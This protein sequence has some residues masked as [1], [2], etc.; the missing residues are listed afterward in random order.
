V[1]S[2]LWRRAAGVAVLAL[3]VF[4]AVALIPPY[5]ENYMF[6]QF[7]DNVSEKKQTPEAAQAEIVN[8]AARLGLPVRAGDVHV[9]RSANGIRVDIIYVVR[10]DLPLYTVDLHFHPS[11]AS[12]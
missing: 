1:N 2:S 8:Q 12:D 10:V 9:T 3:L 7:L 6:Q 4:V 11:A 5:N